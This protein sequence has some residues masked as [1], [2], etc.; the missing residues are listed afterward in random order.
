MGA[1][2]KYTTALW[3]QKTKAL[4]LLT[5][6]KKMSNVNVFVAL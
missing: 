3:G 1:Y 5:I 4:L 6:L 2:Q